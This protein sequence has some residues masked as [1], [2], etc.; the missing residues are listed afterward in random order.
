MSSLLKQF[1]MDLVDNDDKRNAV[2]S[3][4]Y[5]QSKLLEEYCYF[6]RAHEGKASLSYE[7]L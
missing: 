2:M 3:G 5:A 6:F 1:T 4:I 7:Y